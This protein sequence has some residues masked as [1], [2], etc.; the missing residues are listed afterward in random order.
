MKKLSRFTLVL[1]ALALALNACVPQAPPTPP[2][3]TATPAVITLDDG[4]GG[5]LQLTQA[6]RRIVS[7]APSNTEILFAVGAGAQVVAREDF[8][9]YPEEATAIPSVGGNMG[10]YSMEQIVALQP[11]LVLATPL[12][13]SETLQSMQDLKLPVM[14]IPNPTDLDGMYANLELVGRATGHSDVATQL[15]SDLKAR[16]QKVTDVVAQASSKPVVFY[17]LDATDPAKPWTSGPGTFLD[18]LVSMAGGQNLGDELQS[19][20]AQISQE[21]LIVKNPDV[22]LMGD[23]LYGGVTAEQVAARPGWSAIKAVQENKV[24]PFNDDLVSRPGP[25]M[26]DGLEELARVIHPELADQLK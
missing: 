13:A 4:L 8:S 14:L 5:Q 22:I 26:I 25:R 10:V 3:A 21:E 23:S 17:E 12:T 6:A 7:L 16:A 18:K 2:L 1:V 20:W 24:Y 19:E 9:N 15:V 11:D